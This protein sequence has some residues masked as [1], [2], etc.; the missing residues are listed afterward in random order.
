MELVF[1]ALVFLS[2]T[3]LPYCSIF[4]ET[5]CLYFLSVLLLSLG[6]IEEKKKKKRN[7]CNGKMKREQKCS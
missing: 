6:L 2:L 7:G 5:T 4:V 1:Q 3:V